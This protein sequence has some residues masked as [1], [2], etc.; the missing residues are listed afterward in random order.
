MLNLQK[1]AT[2]VRYF[3]QEVMT[4][5]YETALR[6]FEERFQRLVQAYS[7][8]KA[9][10]ADLQQLLLE[11]TDEIA[12]LRLANSELS[13]KYQSLKIARAFGQSEA[14]KQQAY[15]RITGLVRKIDSCINMLT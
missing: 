15:R 11:K 14:D 6:M 8:L 5:E 7:A 1:S 13:K 2:F 4:T 10:N 9:K 12:D 3:R